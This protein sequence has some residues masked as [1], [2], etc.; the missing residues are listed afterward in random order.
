MKWWPPLPSIVEHA[1]ADR[2]FLVRTVRYLAGEEG[3]RQFLDIGTGLPTANNTHEVAQPLAP[4]SRIVYADNDP[5]V[6]AH[7]RAL[8]TSPPEG[9]WTTSTG[10]CWTPGNPGRGGRTLDFTRPVAT[11]AAGVL[12]HVSDTDEAYS[13]VRGLVAALASGSF[14]AITTPPTCSRRGQ[15]RRWRNGTSSGHP[16]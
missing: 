14:V 6:L 2:A 1:R 16:R 8:L 3:I 7:A 4:E 13:I 11:H 12:H 9:V 10:T 5:L 15:K